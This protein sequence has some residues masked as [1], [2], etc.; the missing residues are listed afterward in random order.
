MV[1]T[2]GGVHS[3][4]AAGVHPRE[5]GCVVVGETRG[6]WGRVGEISFFSFWQQ[7]SNVGV[8]GS[9]LS[10]PLLLASS[11]GLLEELHNVLELFQRSLHGLQSVL[12]LHTPLL[13]VGN[14]LRQLLLFLLEL[15]ALGF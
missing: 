11:R 2:V 8:R 14:D 12:Q 1:A 15:H 6:R 13:L 9:C 7:T 5:T 10:L 3:Q 4:K